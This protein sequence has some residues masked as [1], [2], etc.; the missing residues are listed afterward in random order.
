MTEKKVPFEARIY[1]LSH[2]LNESPKCSNP[3]C[4][5]HTMWFGK[6]KKFHKYCCRQCAYSDEEHWKRVEETNLKRR[7]VRFTWQSKDVISK[8][9]QTWKSKYGTEHPTQT[10][11]V[12]EK[13]RETN[14]K[15]YGVE[16]A[17]QSEMVRKKYKETCLK[18]FGVENSSLN[19]YVQKKISHTISS[20]EC[21]TQTKSTN[22][23]KYGA[24]HF[25]MTPEFHQKSHKPYVN[26]KYP[27]MTFGSSWE[28]LVYDFLIEN[29]IEFEYQPNISF[30]YEYDGRN[31]TYHPDFK[32]GDGIFE[33]KGDQFFRINESTCKEEMF[34][35]WGRKKLGEERWKWLCGKYE[36]KH[37]CMLKNNVIILKE[38]EIKHLTLNKFNDLLT[39]TP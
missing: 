39:N 5:K 4:C 2:D 15:R 1:C 14:L 9:K 22:L 26:S 29:N 31:W 13:R 17:F 16:I 23:E 10:Q 8:R 7:G 3:K 6:E 28:F 38:S 27:D 37:Q 21:Q 18:K 36:A 33:V 12:Q 19:K 20:I 34:C 24:L 25:S 11:E 32:V 30:E 35:P